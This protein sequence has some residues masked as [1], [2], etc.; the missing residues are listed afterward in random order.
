MLT[1]EYPPRV[2]GGISRHVYWICKSMAKVGVEVHVVTLDFPNTPEYEVD[3]LLHI[4]RVKVEVGSPNFYLWVMLFNHFFE[5][6]VGRLINK[7][8]PFDVIHAHDWLTITSGVALKHLLSKPLIVT[9]HST[10]MGRSGGLHSP[11]SHMIHGLEW[12]G[13][14]E[15]AQVITVSKYM[16]DE[17]IRLYKLPSD[18]VQVISNGID[19]KTFDVFV[20]KDIVKAKLGISPNEKVILAIGR[21]TWQKGF[22]DLIKAFPKV[23]A[24]HPNSRLVIIGDGYMKGELERLAWNMGLGNKVIFTGFISDQELI[25][26]LKSSDALVISSRYE[27]FGIVALE[28]MA[29]GLP[30]VV[31]NVGGLAEI[32]EHEK[33]GIWVYAN[34]PDSIAWGI[35][36]V[37]SD[38]A[39]AS[40]IIFNGK[41]KVKKYDWSV[42]T[43]KILQVYEISKQVVKFE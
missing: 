19:V 25:E 24:I 6:K 20:N 5:K 17:L 4:H 39:L 43:Q 3:G 30:V 27:P 16:K 35:N 37:L 38:Q 36:R 8:G 7:F 28:G 9:F 26:I 14:F 33:D 13:S 12:W 32:V 40:Q 29:S 18:K 10:E 21:L 11:E 42:I 34:N 23:L 22:D 41:E 1:W 15:A 2:I 31:T